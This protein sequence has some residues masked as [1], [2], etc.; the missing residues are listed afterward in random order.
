MAISA[1]FLPVEQETKKY[2]QKTIDKVRTNLLAIM[3]P[4]RRPTRNYCHS[5]MIIHLKGQLLGTSA[6]EIAYR[7]LGWAAPRIPEAVTA[8]T[9][10]TKILELAYWCFG[11]FLLSCFRSGQKAPNKTDDGTV[12]F[13]KPG[14]L[15]A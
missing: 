12:G 2:R 14:W 3:L 10:K 4:P 5:M 9:P 7:G 13:L 15:Q 1:S 6:D 11:G 8:N